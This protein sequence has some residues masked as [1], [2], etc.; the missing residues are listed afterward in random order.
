MVARSSSRDARFMNLVDTSS[1]SSCSC[2]LRVCF[3]V[4]HGHTWLSTATYPMV[5]MGWI[6]ITQRHT[7]THTHREREILSRS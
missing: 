3:C 5:P 7:H 2:A 4:T 6:H 1:S